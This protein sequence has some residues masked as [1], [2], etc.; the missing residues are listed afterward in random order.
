[1][2]SRAIDFYDNPEL[3]VEHVQIRRSAP[4]SPAVLPLRTWQSVR[5]LYPDVEPALEQRMDATC[6]VVE[7]YQHVG[8]P[9]Q[10]GPQRRRS[11]DVLR[12]H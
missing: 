2:P 8:P 3:G 5:A 6:D 12:P 11:L 9:A 4:A 7:R 1:V 10:P